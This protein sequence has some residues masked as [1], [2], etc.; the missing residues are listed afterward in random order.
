MGWWEPK[1]ST[2]EMMRS[3]TIQKDGTMKNKLTEKLIAGFSL[4]LGAAFAPMAGAQD[5]CRFRPGQLSRM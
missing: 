2:T 5:C 1:H 3:F 4:A